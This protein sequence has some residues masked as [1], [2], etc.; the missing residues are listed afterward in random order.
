MYSFSAFNQLSPE[1]ALIELLHCCGSEKWATKVVNHFP[2]ESE[3]QLFTTVREA[4]YRD[5]QEADYL[6]AFGQ[7]PRIGDLESLKIK[8]QATAHLATSEQ[9]GVHEASEEVLLAFSNRNSDYLEK[10]G[11]IF[12]VCATDKSASEMLRLLEERLLHSREEEIELAMA[13]QHKITLLRLRKSID[14]TD[15]VWSQVSQITTHVLDTSL[16][17]PGKN[18]CIRLKKK[19]ATEY[20]TLAIG[21]TNSDGRITNLMPSGVDLEPGHYQ[22]CFDTGFYFKE[23]KIIAFYPKVDIDF[24]TFDESHYHVPLLINPFGY[25]TYRGS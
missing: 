5:C 24:N 10:N 21:I 8:Y 4:W 23:Q 17:K 19:T 12:L 16:G 18:I 7:H 25:T 22:M 20:R 6:Q 15:A 11:F 2:F 13:E 3:I 1:K 9:S 14:L